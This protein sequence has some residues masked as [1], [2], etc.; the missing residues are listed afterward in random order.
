MLWN[1][2]QYAYDELKMDSNHSIMHEEG[3]TLFPFGYAG[4][5]IGF[6]IIQAEQPYA[7]CA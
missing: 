2:S 7:T 3:T 5:R 4:K 6:I 1:V